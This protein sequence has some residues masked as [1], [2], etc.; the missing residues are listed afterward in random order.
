[1][2]FSFSFF[3]SEESYFNKTFQSR[4]DS[5]SVQKLRLLTHVSLR[6]PSFIASESFLG[7]W[8]ETQNYLVV[9]IY[10]SLLLLFEITN[11]QNQTIVSVECNECDS[12]V[13][14]FV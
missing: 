4:E 6:E 2:P 13:T 7:V 5:G 14:L 1:M 10:C 9:P 12:G 3:K 8:A 11:C